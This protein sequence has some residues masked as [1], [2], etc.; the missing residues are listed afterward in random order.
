MGTTAEKLTYL[1]E[2]KTQLKDMLNLGGASL[3]TEP[4]RQYVDTLKNRYLYFMNNGTQQVWDNWTKTTGTGTTL[5]L[6]NTEEAPMSLVYKGNTLQN[7]TPTPDSPV[8]IQV[9]S[10]D[11]SIV[12]CGKNLFDYEN[13]IY[14]DGYYKNSSGVET[15]DSGLGYITNYIKVE[16]NTQYTLSGTLGSYGYARIYYY[17]SSKTWIS[18]SNGY[19][20][21]TFTF[22]TPNNCE[23]IQFSYQKNTIIK[24][25]VMIEKSNQPTTYEPYT[26]ESYP[27][28]L[29]S[30]NLFDKSSVSKGYRLTT[31][32]G[33]TTDTAYYT[34]DFIKVEGSTKYIKNSPTADAYHRFCFYSSNSESSFLSKSEDNAITTPATCQY[35][36]I[37]GLREEID[38]TIVNEGDTLLPYQPYFTPIQLLHIPNTDYYDKIDKSTGKNL[39]DL[40]C[41]STTG[42]SYDDSTKTYTSTTRTGT[43][44]WYQKIEATNTNYTFSVNSLTNAEYRYCFSDSNLTTGNDIV[45]LTN[46]SGATISNGNMTVS[47]TNNLKYL[48]ISFRTAVNNTSATLVQPM[49]NE[50]STALPYEPYGTSWYL[51]KEIGKVVLDGSETWNTSGKTYYINIGTKRKLTSS[52]SNGLISNHF[53]DTTATSSA[54]VGLG[55]MF[56]FFNASVPNNNVGFNYDDA[57]GGVAGFKTWLSTNNVEVLYILA[58]P[59]Y[60]L[61]EDTTLISQLE[62][63]KSKTGQTNISQTNNDLP[64]DL[65]VIALS[66]E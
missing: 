1:N 57:V 60:T 38:S 49:L 6:N 20:E 10:G 31:T 25:S 37:C 50:G 26:G 41:D 19:S 55:E 62:A 63:L 22:T 56:E 35:I 48:Y 24:S 4:F 27:I 36:R 17:N 66:Q 28:N 9:V 51:K 5:T 61:I 58:T 23:Y 12:V 18:R 29:S 40:K 52:S 44:A 59:T 21:L 43:S 45:S 30:S 13:A 7:G 11:N 32:G 3:T 46:N 64:F 54:N 34:S 16:P 39:L 14:K 47:N 2:T 53:K 8:P 15:S 65:N 42:V 33:L